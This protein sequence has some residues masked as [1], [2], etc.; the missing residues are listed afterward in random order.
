MFSTYIFIIGVEK[1]N[2]KLHTIGFFFCESR[3][4]REKFIFF[5]REVIHNLISHLHSYKAA[6]V[7]LH[8]AEDTEIIIGKNK[9]KSMTGFF[10]GHIVPHV[11]RIGKVTLEQSAQ[12]HSTQYVKLIH[13]VFA[14]HMSTAPHV[15]VFTCLRTLV[16]IGPGSTIRG[17]CLPIISLIYNSYQCFETDRWL[18]P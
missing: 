17:L 15:D 13:D 9:K 5:K 12:L 4:Y 8:I 14:L 6:I 10:L 3:N 18:V 11:L 7:L 1:I 16:N 2:L